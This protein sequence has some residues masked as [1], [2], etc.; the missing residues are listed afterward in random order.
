MAGGALRSPN[1][2]LTRAGKSTTIAPITATESCSRP[3]IKII[4]GAI[5][6]NGT[7]RRR[8]ASG[9]SACSIPFDRVKMK[10]INV[11]RNI[12]T[13]KPIEA[14]SMVCPSAVIT[15]SRFSLALGTSTRNAKT[16]RGFFPMNEL[17][18]KTHKEINQSAITVTSAARVLRKNRIILF[19]RVLIQ[20]PNP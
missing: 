15:S 9:I 16:S 11:A 8:I 13:T 7:E 2:M 19:P 3:N 20:S 4:I 12:P 6:I 1:T 17:T 5:A 14:S 10:A 18:L